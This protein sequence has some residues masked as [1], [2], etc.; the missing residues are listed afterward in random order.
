MHSSGEGLALRQLTHRSLLH[1]AEKH[2][3]LIDAN[4]HTPRSVR[5]IL[6]RFR[7]SC[8]GVILATYAG[9]RSNDY[10]LLHINWQVIT[11]HAFDNDDR[12]CHSEYSG[13]DYTILDEGH[14]IRNPDAQITQVMRA[15]LVLSCRRVCGLHQVRI[16]YVNMQICKRLRCRH[17]IILTG[18]PVQ[19]NL[20][21]VK[22]LSCKCAAELHKLIDTRL[23]PI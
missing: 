3:G 9:L 22:K 1:K 7:R 2:T 18:A 23:Q 16:S 13:R 21:E 11:C 17:R 15:W 20:K 10:K 19:N 12:E 6:R 4:V 14:R 5:I 8:I